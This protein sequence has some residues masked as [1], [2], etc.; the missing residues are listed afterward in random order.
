MGY[1]LSEW[2]NEYLKY[3]EKF[4]RKTFEEKK[5]VFKKFF[6]MIDHT[7]QATS[8]T[9]SDALTYLHQQNKDRSGYAANKDRKNL[10]AAWEWGKKFQGFPN[11]NPFRVVDRFSEKR[12]PRYVPPVGD[13][14]EVYNVA[15][16]QDKV[17]LFTFLHTAGRRSEIFRLSWFEDIDFT[18]CR[19]RLYTRKTRGGNEEFEWLKMTDELYQVLFQHRQTTDSQW[20]FSDPITGDRYYQRD[21]W[22]R[23]LCKKAGVRH[24]GMHAIRHLTA[25]I[26]LQGNIPM[27][28]IREIL[29]HKKVSTT[30]RYVGRISSTEAALKVIS[31]RTPKAIKSTASGTAAVRKGKLNVAK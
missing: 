31:G 9:P 22:M 29:R 13:F 6:H 19:I 1:S 17:M 3:S 8:L 2:A 12:Q 26:L 27:G 5:S 11:I 25:N 20:V 18:D 4:S 16:G 14:W 24:F 21:R 15:E 23:D 7:R 10:M 28:E 30:E